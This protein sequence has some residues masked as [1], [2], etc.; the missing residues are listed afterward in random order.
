MSHTTI[1]R[2]LW[3]NRDSLAIRYYLRHKGKRYRYGDSK[4][5]RIPNRV[6]ITKRPT[7][8]DNKARIGDW[9]ADTVWGKAGSGAIVTLVDRKSKY[10]LIRKIKTKNANN[11]SKVII[12]AL[13]KLKTRVKTITYDNGSEFTKHEAIN[14]KLN[15]KSYFAKPYSSWQRG[16]N[17]HTNG[18]IR[19]W[20]PKGSDFSYLTNAKCKYLQNLLNNRPRKCLNFKSPAE[21]F[22]PQQ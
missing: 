7:V 16:L 8:A 10:T 18:L 1:Y 9:E 17:E 21:V 11:T 22:S 5:A 19:Q 4:R 3:S 15:C 12:D 6:D 20:L 14:Q 2:R 13:N